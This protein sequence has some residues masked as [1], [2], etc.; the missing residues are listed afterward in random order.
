[1]HTHYKHRP[2]YSERDKKRGRKTR[3]KGT[4]PVTRSNAGGGGG[5]GGVSRLAGV[6]TTET[7]G[8]GVMFA[9]SRRWWKVG[10]TKGWLPWPEVVTTLGLP[11]E[12]RK[13][14]VF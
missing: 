10:S 7:G 6:F 5:R 11:R 13:P 8:T 2:K 1:M 9:H 12:R 4:R 3:G 14:G